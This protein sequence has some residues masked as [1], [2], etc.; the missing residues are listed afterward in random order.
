ML[1]RGLVRMAR[2]WSGEYYH[3]AKSG[4]LR[5][6][7]TGEIINQKPQVVVRRGQRN[8]V[9]IPRGT[10]VLGVERRLHHFSGIDK[11]PILI[12]N[13]NVLKTTRARRLRDM[14]RNQQKAFF[15]KMKRR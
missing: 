6:R 9:V 13:A 4:T 11:P 7:R 14:P 2:I 8:L 10:K 12:K 3:R 1:G 15:A 5:N